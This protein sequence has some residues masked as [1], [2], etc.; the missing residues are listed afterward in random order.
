MSR[1]RVLGVAVAAATFFSAFALWLLRGWGGPA[2]VGAVGD[3]GSVLAGCFAVFCAV[4]T[5][6]RSAGR[7]RRAWGMLAAAIGCWVLGDSVWMLNS[8]VLHTSPFPSLADLGYVLFY[9]CACA[10]VLLLFSASARLLIRVLF[11]GLMVA[12]SLFVIFWSV[13]L[14]EMFDN[15]DAH[16][17][18][19]ALSV[20]YFMADLLL[21][22]VATLILLTAPTGQRA[23]LLTFALGI[24]LLAVADGV[25]VVLD[26][27]GQYS[28]GGFVDMAW[29]A[30]L[31][32]LGVA[33][34]EGAR[35]D[36]RA[37]ETVLTPSR[38]A[39]WMPY[40][41]VTG[42]VVAV[43]DSRGS[44]PLLLAS[45]LVVVAVIGRQFVVSDENR[46]LLASLS[47]QA[48]RD[49]LTGLANR[50]M[51]RDRLTGAL[52]A[53]RRDRRS[54][55]LLSVDLDDFKSVNDSLGHIAGDA[56]LIAVAERLRR[57]VPADQVV[58][59]L[60]GDEF[61]VLL[62]DSAESPHDVA[63][64]V[65]SSFDNP[66]PVDGHHVLA[67][68]S[69]GVTT[70]DGAGDASEVDALLKQADMA[71]YSAKRNGGGVRHFAVEMQRVEHDSL[72]EN[73]FIPRRGRTTTLQFA[74][75]LRHALEHGELGVVY[76]PQ[77][78]VTSG[79]IIAVEALVRWHHPQ[80]GM[81]RPDEFLPV[82]RHNDLMGALTDQVL[83]TAVRDNARWRTDGFEIPFA[84]N[85]FP[86][87]LGD[88]RLPEHLAEILAGGGLGG[89]CL[90]VEITEDVL[91]AHEQ[92]AQE[93]LYRLRS[94]G[95]R[96]SIDD[97]GS[98]Y[99]GLNYLRQIQ[100]DEVKLDRNLITPMNTDGRAEAIVAAMI[101]LSHT[102]GLRCVAE[103][104][105]DSATVDRLAQLDCDVMQGFY[106]GP[107]MSASHM[108]DALAG[109]VA[110]TAKY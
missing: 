65:F 43:V 108:Q 80:R 85:L 7:R 14:G 104:V 23:V 78:A 15:S 79:D 76:Q 106:C 75:Q 70:T 89:D 33:A 11:D 48:S 38:V 21:I 90:T 64:Q 35:T 2:T 31:L 60:G 107:P 73:K 18:A 72:W 74:D 71:M 26:A 109:Y 62:I 9:L 49:S 100:V 34:T 59:R 58:A 6:R 45:L 102:L 24:G 92:A 103:G 96:I 52:L 39:F 46:R 47:E 22:T 94:M 20:T 87:S 13:G 12:S 28:S 69:I 86:P 98:G 88:P 83:Q 57:C 63:H 10:A 66:F 40:V 51:F 50:T 56:L 19:F 3:V 4:S 99:A 44:A 84:I 105:Q 54:I 32:L 53:Q 1:S 17:F 29:V 27:R 36:H 110:P 16:W 25:F 77:F 93:V 67:R 101:G 97:F 5:M 61:A 37:V 8:L 95:I 42:A 91:L 41:P 81:L 68:A 30:G 82:V 55:A